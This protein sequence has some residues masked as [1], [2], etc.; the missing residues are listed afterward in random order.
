MEDQRVLAILLRNEN[1]HLDF[2]D[3]TIRKKNI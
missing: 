3:D 2:K 1:L